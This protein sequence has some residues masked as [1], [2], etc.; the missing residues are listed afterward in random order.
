[1]LCATACAQE[2]RRPIWPRKPAFAP[3]PEPSSPREPCAASMASVVSCWA[4]R[5]ASASVAPTRVYCSSSRWA[6]AHQRPL[7]RSSSTS[8]GLLRTSICSISVGDERHRCAGDVAEC[9]AAVAEDARDTRRCRRRS[10]LAARGRRRRAR[11]RASGARTRVLGVRLDARERRLGARALDLELG[12]EDRVVAAGAMQVDDRPL[13]RQ[14]PE[15]GEVRDVRRIEEHVAARADRPHVLEQPRT[16]IRVLFG[17]DHAASIEL[18]AASIAYGGS[19]TSPSI[20]S[21]SASSLARSSFPANRSSRFSADANFVCALPRC[22]PTTLEVFDESVEVAGQIGDVRHHLVCVLLDLHPRSP[23]AI[24]WRYA[25]NVDGDIGNTRRSCA[26]WRIVASA[27]GDLVVDRLDRDVHECEVG[28][29]L[30][31]AHVLHGDRIDVDA[32]VARERLLREPSLFVGRRLD[33]ALVVVERELRVDRNQQTAG[34]HRRVDALAGR[35]AVLHLER[36]SGRRSRRRF[37]SSSSPNPPRAFGGRSAC[38]RRERS[39]ARSSICAA[40]L[41]TLP[42]RSWI[43]VDVFCAVSRRRSTLCRVGRAGGRASHRARSSRRSTATSRCSSWRAVAPLSSPRSRQASPGSPAA[44]GQ[45]RQGRRR[46]PGPRE[47]RVG[48]P[49][50]DER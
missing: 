39:F 5:L 13:V 26:Y 6:C 25:V 32:H 16:A 48:V 49:W 40:A 4:R 45:A 1:M 22:F 18:Y 37:S 41:S 10:F 47:T 46:R 12:H 30:V 8:A 50:T 20:S 23:N 3:S 9:G 14:E 43:S 31:G 7:S 38:S 19:S 44:P 33:E 11:A 15:A 27:A 2:L 17:R 21:T 34:I 36:G 29:A 28:R 35:E 24:T 42:S